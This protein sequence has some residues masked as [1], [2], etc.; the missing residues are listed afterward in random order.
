MKGQLQVDGFGAFRNS[1][2]SVNGHFSSSTGGHVSR[3]LN[4]DLLNAQLDTMSKTI[5]ENK[6]RHDDD[7][8]TEID[9]KFY[10]YEQIGNRDMI[11]KISFSL[12]PEKQYGT[13]EFELPQSH[14]QILNNVIKAGK[15]WQEKDVTYQQ[16]TK[17]Q[18][19]PGKKKW[20]ENSTLLTLPASELKLYDVEKGAAKD[21]GEI[22][23]TAELGKFVKQVP[24]SSYSIIPSAD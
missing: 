14:W 1:V 17:H 10:Q 21:R 13:L 2:Y 20:S 9:Q 6:D 19:W 23:E 18:P 24:S 3:I 12:R 16:S 15:T 8:K 7:Y 5:S 22:Y 11:K 4:R